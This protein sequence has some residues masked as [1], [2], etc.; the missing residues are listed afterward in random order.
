MSNNIGLNN[1]PANYRYKVTLDREETLGELRVRLV[2][3]LGLFV[4]ALVSVG[5]VYWLCYNTVTSPTAGA[6]EKKWAMSILS[7]TAAGLVGYLVRK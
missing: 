4:F 3:D 2:K 5:A 6:D 1:P 7:A